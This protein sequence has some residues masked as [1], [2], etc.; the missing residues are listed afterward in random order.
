MPEVSDFVSG[1]LLHIHPVPLPPDFLLSFQ[2][3]YSHD[4]LSEKSLHGTT[5]PIF[6]V[7]FFIVICN[8]P[9]LSFP[10]IVFRQTVLYKLLSYSHSYNKY[11]IILCPNLH[12][13]LQNPICYKPVNR[14]QSCH[15]LSVSS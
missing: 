3:P 13:L 9:I 12:F 14:L 2:L 11:L 6:L 4:F 1:S 7:G 15:W 10:N 8:L 5:F